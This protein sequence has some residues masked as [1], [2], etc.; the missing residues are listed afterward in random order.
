[1]I[2]EGAMDLAAF[3]SSPVFVW[4]VLP[5]LIFCMRIIDVSIGTIRIIYVSRSMIYLAALCGFFEILIWLV[6]ITQIM[7]N[8]DNYL[9]YLAYAGGFAA[10]NF[11][12]I[13]LENRLAVGTVAVRAITHTDATDLIEH[14]AKEDFGVTSM[15][16]SGVAG[17]VRLVFSVVKRKD[18][19]KALEIIKRFN[20]RAFISVED[21]RSVREGYFPGRPR[22]KNIPPAS[23]LDGARKAK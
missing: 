14:L 2:V 13:Y 20:P 19:P 12:G 8:L 15:A 6:S 17:E 11:V 5:F 16:A 21:V 3:S 1:M 10:G 9:T 22:I 4:A 18:L 23:H 7:Q